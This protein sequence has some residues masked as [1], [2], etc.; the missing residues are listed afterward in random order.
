[1]ASIDSALNRGLIALDQVTEIFDLLPPRY[2]VLRGL[3]DGRAQSGPETLVRVMVRKLGST[4]DL[5]VEF[6]GVGFVD[7]VVD[8]W[9]VIECDSKAHHSSWEQQLKVRTVQQN[10]DAKVP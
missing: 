3:I 1:M 8:G 2:G 4:A 10:E 6:D 5:Q 7:L 9:L